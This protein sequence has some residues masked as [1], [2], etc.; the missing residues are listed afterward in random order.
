[1]PFVQI[2]MIEGRTVE[3]KRK[4]VQAVTDAIVTTL[5]VPPEAVSIHIKDMPKTNI[6]R[7]GKLRCDTDAVAQPAGK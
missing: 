1:M 4:L 2:N 3:Q 7:A 6:A 5:S